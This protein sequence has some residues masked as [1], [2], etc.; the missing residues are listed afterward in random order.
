MP[1][2]V[3]IE[4][5]TGSLQDPLLIVALRD[6]GGET[7]SAV[8]DL[9]ISEWDAELVA[10][11]DPDPFFDF[12]VERP[13]AKTTDDQRVIEWPSMR[14]HHAH[15]AGSAR[16]VLIL[17]GPEPGLRWRSLIE[18]IADFLRDAGVEQVLSVSTFPGATPHTRAVPLR[19]T[20]ADPGITEPFAVQVVDTHY[21]G[22]IGFAAALSTALRAEE[23]RSGH[24]FGVTPFYLGAAPNPVVAVELVKAIDRGLG[25]STPLDLVQH[26]I[27]PFLDRANE[28][29]QTPQLL[30]V[31]GQ[32]ESQYDAQRPAGAGPVI[33]SPAFEPPDLPSSAEVVADVESLLQRAR[34]ET[35]VG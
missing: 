5:E 24:L 28:L 34:G 8:A 22:P 4:R 19:M 13:V 35:G 7:V 11:I 14:F 31:I 3:R 32:L 12:R 16:D 10:E 6:R 20:A 17:S 15:P 21:Q 23:T 18:A 26:K 33:D 9:L 27:S 25:A 2:I 1:N 29:A 30:E